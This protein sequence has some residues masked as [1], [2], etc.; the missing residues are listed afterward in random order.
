MVYSIDV[1]AMVESAC[2]GEPNY[3]SG[4]K[5]FLCILY[6]FRT[7]E[8]TKTGAMNI[9]MTKPMPY[10]YASKIGMD[11]I[12][13]EVAIPTPTL[14]A[15]FL[16]ARKSL[17]SQLS[18]SKATTG[19]LDFADKVLDST[20]VI[21]VFDP[22]HLT[23]VN[24][25]KRAIM[26]LKLKS[27]C[28]HAYRDAIT[29]E[30]T[31]VK[32]LLCSR[33]P[34]H[35][36]SSTLWSH[37]CWLI[38]LYAQEGYF[39]R[40]L[41]NTDKTFTSRT[42]EEE[43]N[44]VVSLAAERHPMNYSAWTYLRW[45]T[46]GTRLDPPGASKFT[47]QVRRWCENHHNDVSGWTFLLWFLTGRK[48]DPRLARQT[49]TQVSDLAKDLKW[50]GDAVWNFLLGFADSELGSDELSYIIRENIVQVKTK[51]V[52]RTPKHEHGE[53]KYEGSEPKRQKQDDGVGRNGAAEMETPTGPEMNGFPQIEAAERNGS[54][55]MDTPT[56]PIF[57]NTPGA[58]F[59]M[60][61]RSR[62][63]RGWPVGSSSPSSPRHDGWPST[64][65]EI[66]EAED[67]PVD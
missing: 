39:S 24:T 35:N 10:P 17:K 15:A 66:P 28:K 8:F 58:P 9:E 30:L 1:E 51:A 6:V 57:V 63:Y 21:L 52:P 12:N 49:V 23:A 54:Q 36:K 3:C 11:G 32:A 2:F 42:L 41:I 5:A 31:F 60:T 19:P 62:A 55:E 67:V 13:P 29:N 44:S 20:A 4:R 34:R 14:K 25:R 56:G 16:Y 48:V 43:F 50:R 22:E 59:S 64:W 38:K 45:L 18:S 61:A 37:R 27:K 33:L 65:Q 46:S 7:M 53:P 26:L 47:N 40:D